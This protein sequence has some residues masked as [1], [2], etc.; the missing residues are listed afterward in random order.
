VGRDRE[1]SFGTLLQRFRRRAG[2]SQAALATQAGL[3]ASAIG[4]LER[5]ARRRPHPSTLDMLATA[6]GLTIAEKAVLADASWS[7]STAPPAHP[8]GATNADPGASPAPPLVIA[9]A[10]PLPDPLTSFVGRLAEAIELARLVRD[11]A[12]RLVTLTGV[13][14]AGK[15]RLALAVAHDVRP[16]LADG[17]WL[18][19]TALQG[20]LSDSGVRRSV[21]RR[22]GV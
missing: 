16:E 5:G 11:P 13:G 18:V 21:R 4:A 12:V 14:G 9:Q 17:V 2:L 3:A 8:G 15:T 7:P 22:R 20:Q 19:L 1:R 10:P 6:L